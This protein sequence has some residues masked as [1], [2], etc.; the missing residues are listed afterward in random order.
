MKLLKTNCFRKRDSN[1]NPF[2]FVTSSAVEKF[3]QLKKIA[4]NSPT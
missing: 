4:V 2:L 1:E 3:R